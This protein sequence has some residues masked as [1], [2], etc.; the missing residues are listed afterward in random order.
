MYSCYM[1]FLS[2]I[3]TDVI[4]VTPITYDWPLIAVFGGLLNGFAISLC[5]M[6]KASSGGLDFITIYLA[7]KK[8]IDTWNYVLILN[9]LI[10]SI[11]GF[12][13]GWDRALYSIIYQFASTQIVHMMY[14]K[15]RQAYLLID[16]QSSPGSLRDH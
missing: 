10:I 2:S 13:F 12:L 9:G 5:L 7:N 1:I 3:H 4:P 15:H 8:N 11:A 16:Y 6:A 14:R